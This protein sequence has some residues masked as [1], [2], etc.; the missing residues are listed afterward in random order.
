MQLYED[1]VARI[2]GICGIADRLCRTLS[3]LWGGYLHFEWHES[4]FTIRAVCR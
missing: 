3:V 1:D 2:E 4:K